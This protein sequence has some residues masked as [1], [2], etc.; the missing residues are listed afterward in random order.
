VTLSS[1][2]QLGIQVASA[3][4]AAHAAG[5]V[6]RDIKPENIVVLADGQCK[7]LDFG[8][9]KP[10]PVVAGHQPTTI[11]LT[12]AGVRVGTIPYMSPEQ[13]RGEPLD[14]RSDIFSL[15][16][17]LYE[18]ASGIRAFDGAS[19]LSIMHDIATVN[20]PPPSAA[21]REIPVELDLVVQRALTKD[22]AHRYSASELGEALGLIRDSMAPAPAGGSVEESPLD[23]EPWHIVGREAELG[24]LDA[25]L[26]E[27]VAHRGRPIPHYERTRYWE[28]DYRRRVHAPRPPAAGGSAHRSR[29]MRRTIRHRGN[30]SDPPRC[31]WL[32]RGR[33]RRSQSGLSAP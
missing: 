5:I 32:T 9:A 25:A 7:L 29:S 15:G 27:T 11:G 28:D 23:R 13:T 24:R 26:S 4:A 20:P 30:V 31:A 3:L 10:T 21:R 14:T 22:P 6:H 1:V 33:R 2:L 17:V 19:A 12:Q 16:C 18:A 8:L